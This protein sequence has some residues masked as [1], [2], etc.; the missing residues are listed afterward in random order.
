MEMERKLF[1][2]HIVIEKE[3]KSAN[4]NPFSREPW[5]CC[6][7][8]EIPFTG[9]LMRQSRGVIKCQTNAER[10]SRSKRQP[11]VTA[12]SVHR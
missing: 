4:G 10:E 3:R 9:C 6:A 12:R 11:H 5:R 7:R 1:F 8:V 2:P